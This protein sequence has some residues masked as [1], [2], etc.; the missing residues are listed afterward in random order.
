ML[1]FPDLY[2]WEYVDQAINKEAREAVFN[3]FEAIDNLTEYELVRLGAKPTDDFNS[4]PY[5]R[6]TNEA[7]EVYKQW[8]QQINP[9]P[10]IILSN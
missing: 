10:L 2:E 7:Q 4:R 6:F 5:F 3:L 1:I 8:S 9:E